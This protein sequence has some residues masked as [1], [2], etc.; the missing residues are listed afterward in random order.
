ML[1]G[2]KGRLF[3]WTWF[4]FMQQLVWFLRIWH[5]M[6]LAGSGRCYSRLLGFCWKGG[7]GG[8]WRFSKKMAQ[9]FQVH[10]GILQEARIT[11]QLLGFRFWGN[12]VSGAYHIDPFCW[13]CWTLVLF[14]LPTCQIT[15]NERLGYFWGP[16]SNRLEFMSVKYWTITVCR[17]PAIDETNRDMNIFHKNDQMFKYLWCPNGR[18][19]L[20]QHL[21]HTFADLDV[22][23]NIQLI[24]GGFKYFL[25]WPLPGTGK[26]I[27]FD[28][29]PE[30]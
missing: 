16:F 21:H 18:C 8:K 19:F 23:K 11:C 6:T 3:I 17:W 12:H 28:Y 10:H 1:W 26:M 4:L 15:M 25:F 27:T 14:Y 9:I 30:I 22:N 24:G 2:C 5:H 29:T 7:A 20:M 13:M